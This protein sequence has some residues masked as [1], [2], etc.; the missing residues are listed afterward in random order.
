MHL[1]NF[2]LKVS[3]QIELTKLIDMIRTELAVKF[4]VIKICVA[5]G[6]LFNLVT[7]FRRFF[8]LKTLRA[9]FDRENF[10]YLRALRQRTNNLILIKN[11]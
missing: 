6:G 2:F 11:L 10:L 7:L 9:C 1:G 4:L 8:I 5:Q 3:D